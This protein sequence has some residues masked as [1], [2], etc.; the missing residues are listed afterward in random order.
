MIQRLDGYLLVDKNAGWTSQDAVAVLK[1]KFERGTRVGHAGTLDPAATGLLIVLFGRATKVQD[2]F[3]KL[4]KSYSG[5]FQLGIR[6]DTL[7]AD[8]KITHEARVPDLDA[9]ALAREM[10]SYQRTLE[11]EPPAYS[12]LKYKGKPLYKYARAGQKVPRQ[13][14][15]M[16]VRRWELTEFS[17]PFARFEMDCASGTYVRSLVDLLGEKLGCFATLTQLRRT[18]VGPFELEG[19]PTIEELKAMD[20]ASI[21]ALLKPAVVPAPTP[22]ARAAIS[23]PRGSDEA[24]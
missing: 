5:Q 9:D 23:L 22:Q 24:L 10:Q 11:I 17:S 4:P 19:A 3:M 14:K 1:H 6:T 20:G 13:F 16:T 7:D 15:T 21:E 18:Q 8:G 12:A 2:S